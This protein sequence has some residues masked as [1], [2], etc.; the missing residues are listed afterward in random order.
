MEVEDEGGKKKGDDDDKEV[1]GEEKEDDVEKK[2]G[3]SEEIS[4]HRITLSIKHTLTSSM[5]VC[6]SSEDKMTLSTATRGLEE[7]L[8]GES[9]GVSDR[10][11]C[12]TGASSVFDD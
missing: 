12:T 1:D 2:R 11:F 7:D 6:S 8:A 3:R 10:P 5:C 4:M 9:D